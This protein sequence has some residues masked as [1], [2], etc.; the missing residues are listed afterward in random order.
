M[1]ARLTKTS[2][3]TIALIFSTLLL[4]GCGQKSDLYLPDS[5]TVPEFTQQ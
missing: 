4:T 2:R 3:A 5:V 1:S